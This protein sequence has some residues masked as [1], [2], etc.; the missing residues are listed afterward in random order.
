M[1]GRKQG[2]AQASQNTLLANFEVTLGQPLNL[3]ASEFLSIKGGTSTVTFGSRKVPDETLRAGGGIL[4]SRA[5]SAG[6]CYVTLGKSC[7]TLGLSLH[8]GS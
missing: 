5:S 4:G 6:I 3:N 2:S 1:T 7:V 8:N